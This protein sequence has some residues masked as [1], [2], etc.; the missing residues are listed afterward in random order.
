MELAKD[1]NTELLRAIKWH[2]V[3]GTTQIVSTGPTVYCVGD[4][5]NPFLNSLSFIYRSSFNLPNTTREISSSDKDFI[6]FE[7]RF[8]AQYQKLEEHY[9]KSDFAL[10]KRNFSESLS[11]LL[12]LKPDTLSLELTP[13][14]SVYFTLLKGKYSVFIQHYLDVSDSDD[15]EAILSAFRE[16]EKLPSFAGRLSDTLS[17]LRKILFS[18]IE[19]KSWSPRYELSY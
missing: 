2:F 10:V 16:N 11:E 9:G 4:N 17:E 7:A 6:K 13:D 18:P 15:D 19:G 12:K 3:S 8:I 14:K 5:E 1:Q